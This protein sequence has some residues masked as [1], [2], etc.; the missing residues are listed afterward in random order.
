LSPVTGLHALRSAAADW[1]LVA[2][3]TPE[4]AVTVHPQFGELAAADIIRRNAHEAVHHELDIRRD[5][6]RIAT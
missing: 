2:W 5:F 3:D 6:G 1:T 4:A